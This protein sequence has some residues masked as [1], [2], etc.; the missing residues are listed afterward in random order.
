MKWELIYLFISTF[1]VRQF[2]FFIIHIQ[3]KCVIILLYCVE[4]A[5]PVVC[6]NI[7][8]EIRVS[9]VRQQY[10]LCFIPFM[11]AVDPE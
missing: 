8:K 6:N 10:Y 2:F 9:L 7:K 3:S 4:D 5:F 1:C 11:K